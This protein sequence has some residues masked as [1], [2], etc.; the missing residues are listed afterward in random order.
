MLF[1]PKISK[2]EESAVLEGASTSESISYGIMG[3]ED[4]VQTYLLES[5]QEMYEISASLLAADSTIEGTLLE[6]AISMDEAEAVMEGMVADTAN[7]VWSA[8]KKLKDKMVEWFKKVVE[9]LKVTFMNGKRFVSE[10][11]PKLLAKN[12]TPFTVKMYPYTPKAGIDLCSKNASA[13]LAA[14][15]TLKSETD[16][17]VLGDIRDNSNSEKLDEM[18]SK[19]KAHVDEAKSKASAEYLRKIFRGGADKK[20]DVK[21]EKNL[22]SNYIGFVEKSDAVVNAVIA[23]RDITLKGLDEAMKN[24]KTIGGLV[25]NEKDANAGKVNAAISLYG[26]NVRALA[27]NANTIA[28]V[29]VSM[30]KEIAGAYIAVLKRVAKG[31]NIGVAGDASTT[32]ALPAPKTSIATRDNNTDVA[33]KESVE[34]TAE[35][36]QAAMEAVAGIEMDLNAFVDSEEAVAESTTVTELEEVSSDIADFIAQVNNTIL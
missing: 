12:F 24:V 19:A 10:Y 11:K 4:E 34:P 20:Q 25:K 7:K 32:N 29:E 23:I 5:A 2:F 28:G 21:V 16:V 8:L 26:T 30:V 9:Y 13:I 1:G 33:V 36:M 14:V 27:A 17:V 35:E 22:V 31:K 6:G 3:T 15:A 18:R